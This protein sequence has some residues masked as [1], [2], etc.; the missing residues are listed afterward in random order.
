MT[1]VAPEPCPA[2]GS[3]QADLLCSATDR[4]YRTT[5]RIFH[6][7]ACRCCRLIRLSPRPTPDQLRSYY[8]E[9]YWFAPDE[10]TAGRL[11]E[12]YR[13]FVLGDHVRFVHRPLEEAGLSG[14]ILDVGC[15]GGLFLR[16]LQER[17]YRVAGLDFSIDAAILAWR[18][19]GVPTVCASL[20]HAP[21]PPASCAAITM[22]H[23]L[24]HLYDPLSYLAAA[25]E[26]LRPEGRLFVQ[27]PNAGCWQF[28]LLGE[29]WSGLDVPRHLITFRQRDLE[30]LLDR[31]GFDI[32]RVKHFSLRDNPAG[33]AT[34]LAPWLDPVARRVR[35]VGE[36]P[37]TRLLKDLLYFC[38]VCCCLPFAV[39]EA[40][41]HAGST[42]MI[43]ARKK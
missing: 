6:V 15:G 38:L 16:L 2:C 19:N 28:L 40:A 3:S 14:L 26:L 33:M 27:V 7:V 21:F 39:L 17:G 23:V 9:E 42:I 18:R 4:L 43:E 32:V 13:R 10:A 22:F 34:S 37:T 5:D 25:Y 11:E 1:A 8:P 31:T 24:E 20:T 35:K 30:V 36:T 29:N 12:A 41:C